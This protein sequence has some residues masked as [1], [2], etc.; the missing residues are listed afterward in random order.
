MERIPQGHR[1]VVFFPSPKGWAASE[2]I[3]STGGKE[4]P[5]AGRN[6]RYPLD[7]PIEEGARPHFV[8][9]FLALLGHRTLRRWPG[10]AD[11]C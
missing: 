2:N 10:R 8:Q 6:A 7:R 3:A 1:P 11:A 4:V 9:R 5:S